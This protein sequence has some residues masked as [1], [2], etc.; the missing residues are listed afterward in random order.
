MVNTPLWKRGAR[1]D[2]TNA[3]Q[4]QSF[5]NLMLDKYDIV[6]FRNARTPSMVG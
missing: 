1:G 2:F 3:V 4:V 6:S 5:K